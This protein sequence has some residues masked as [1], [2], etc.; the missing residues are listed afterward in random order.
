MTFGAAS[1]KKRVDVA[2]RNSIQAG[3]IPGPR[4]LANAQEMAPREG[5]L[6]AGITRYVDSVEEI[7]AAIAEFAE[8]GV[9]N[10]KFSMSGEEITEHLR[11]EDTTFPDDLVAAG[12]EVRSFRFLTEDVA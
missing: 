9:D 12:V 4:S 1:A 11:A 10:V 2:V 5:A 6:V 7:E 3:D 8:M